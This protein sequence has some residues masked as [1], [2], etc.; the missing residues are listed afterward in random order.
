MQI[1]C[2]DKEMIQQPG[3]HFLNKDMESCK[4]NGE[5]LCGFLGNGS[6]K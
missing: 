5:T 2:E 6:G 4:N 3:E 1:E